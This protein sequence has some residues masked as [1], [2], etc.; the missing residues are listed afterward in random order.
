MTVVID[1]MVT[2]LTTRVMLRGGG[3]DVGEIM[4]RDWG[5]MR[6]GQRIR[7][8]EAADSS[9]VHVGVVSTIRAL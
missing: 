6:L 7:A 5:V 4:W 2:I 3:G 8:K 9:N 1:K